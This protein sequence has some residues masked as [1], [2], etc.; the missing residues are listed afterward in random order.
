MLGRIHEAREVSAGMM[1]TC[2][3]KQDQSILCWGRNDMGQGGAN[4]PVGAIEFPRLVQF[5]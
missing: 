5:D 1:T 2:A 4:T 3:R